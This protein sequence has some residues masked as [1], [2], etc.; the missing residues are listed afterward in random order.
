MTF[1]LNKIREALNQSKPAYENQSTGDN[2]SYPFWNAKEKE[3]VFLR[4]LPDGDT[5]NPFFWRHRQVIKLPFAGVVGESDQPVEVQVPCIKMWD[6]KAVCPITQKMNVLWKGSE[7]D[8]AIA[9]IYKR[10]HT[11]IYQGFV[12]QSPIEEETV[13]EN[14]IR[15][16]VIN[17]TIHDIIEKSLHDTDLEYVPIDYENGLEFKISKEKSPGQQ[18]AKY[19][20][21]W[22]QKTTPLTD[23]QLVAIETF[24]LFN[25]GEFLGRRPD[26][27]ELAVQEA[28]LMDSRAGKQFDKASYG[29]LY[30]AYPTRSGGFVPQTQA[31]TN[32]PVFNGYTPNQAASQ[33]PVQEAQETASQS[34]ASALLQRLKANQAA[35]AGG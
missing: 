10:H 7:S 17:K 25:L 8:Q 24:G 34:S 3:T 12:I 16:F 18:F 33:V 32:T 15:R 29:H 6:D 27:D 23:E 28:M 21:S 13:P 4:F 35:Q 31:T 22:R 19:I 9:R 1:D 20:C 26:A 2:A 14:P 11:Y 30:R 5:N